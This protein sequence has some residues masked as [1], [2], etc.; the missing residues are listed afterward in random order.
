VRRGEALDLVQAMLSGH[1]GA[2]STVHAN[3]PRDAAIRLETLCLMSDVSLPAHVARIQVASAV[4]LVIQIARL[5]DGS[6]RIMEI[7]ECLGLGAD[8]QYRLQELFRFSGEGRDAAGKIVGQLRPTG[9]RPSFAAEVD[10]LGY[11]DRILLTTD[12]FPSREAA[13]NSPQT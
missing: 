3:T 11:R 9:G 4:H 5:P 6:R 7:T 8:G 2:L 1:T 13:A 12:L 10:A